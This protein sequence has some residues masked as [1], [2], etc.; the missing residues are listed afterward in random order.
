M[1]I[2]FFYNRNLTKTVHILLQCKR[3]C[4]CWQASSSGMRARLNSGADNASSWS[5]VSTTCGAA[6]LQLLL[7]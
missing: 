5:R 6:V 4:T 2:F 7:V 3:D 1:L